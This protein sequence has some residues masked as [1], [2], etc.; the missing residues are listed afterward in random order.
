MRRYLLDTHLIYWWMTADAR[1]GKATQG[2]IA[3]SEIIVSTASVW[4]MVLKNAKGKLP[5]P[6]GAIT[7][8]LEAQGFVLLPIL[9]R[10]IE[11]VR[12]LTCTHADPFDRL[13]IAQA[14]DERLT[15]LTRDAAILAMG[16]DG[17]VKG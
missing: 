9:P 4:E 2:L 7:E 1:L 6:Q 10:H 14:Q 12:G 15:L 13:L 3:K 16:L 11:T 17:V 8:Q 5:L